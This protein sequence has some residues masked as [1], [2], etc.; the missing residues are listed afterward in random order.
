MSGLR[1]LRVRPT[2]PA[3]TLASVTMAMAAWAAVAHNSGSGWVQA[4][5]VCIGSVLVV[6]LLGGWVALRRTL[7][8][9]SSN[10][11]D[12]AAGES[13][14]IELL[15]MGSVRLRPV[16]PAGPYSF[17]SPTPD[18]TGTTGPTPGPTPGPPPSLTPA[19]TPGLL[20][21]TV[22]S[23]KRA[24]SRALPV[25]IAIEPERRGV[26]RRVEIEV[27]SAAPFGI[28][29]WSG[30]LSLPLARELCVSPR[31]GQALLQ[32]A[33]GST[34]GSE[35]DAIG[36]DAPGR[37][38]AGRRAA[39]GA[40][41]SLA[42]LSLREDRDG[43]EPAGARSYEPGDELRHVHWPASAHTGHLM[44]RRRESGSASSPVT[45]WANLP[46]DPEE[47]ERAAENVM[48]TACS[49]LDR[50]VPV[51]LGTYDDGAPHLALVKSRRQA[52][53]RLAR[54]GPPRAAGRAEQT[55]FGD[56]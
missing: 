33:A 16:D 52:G 19:R 11:A 6:G 44:V 37:S 53:R 34:P 40:A 13:S 24:R 47:A 55:G 25:K 29:W 23:N 45:I 18:P 26:Y 54:A 8:V 22:S 3:R 15:V 20:A 7:V 30:R 14:T 10:P 9:C 51:A 27:A 39:D 21:G 38:T 43:P 32:V 41:P 36:G 42:S 12:A 5:G 35:D 31:S 2:R 50:R 49:L 28:M 1:P 46:A 4:I 48:G 17:C 56:Q